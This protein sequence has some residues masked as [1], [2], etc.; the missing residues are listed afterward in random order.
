MHA[1]AAVRR[2]AWSTRA[3]RNRIAI[4]CPARLA[5]RGTGRPDRRRLV[6]R[7]GLGG[8]VSKQIPLVDYLVL[9]SDPHLVAHECTECG[10]RYFDRRNACA[11]CEGESFRD[12]VVPTEGELR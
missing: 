5:G 4:Q 8:H 1:S 2:A 11:S 6:A 9:G 12:V 10:A 3:R 7:T